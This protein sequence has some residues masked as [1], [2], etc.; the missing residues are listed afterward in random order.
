MNTKWERL[1][2]SFAEDLSLTAAVILKSPKK[3]FSFNGGELFPAASL[4]KLPILW[5]LYRRFQLGESQPDEKAILRQRVKVDGCGILKEL[6]DGLEVTLRDLAT[7]MIVLSDNTAT[8]MLIEKLGMDSINATCEKLGMK[9]TVLSRIMMDYEAAKRGRDNLTT[10]EDMAL[11]FQ[12]LLDGDELGE[13]FRKEMTDILLRQQCN[14]KIPASLPADTPFAHKTGEVP[15]A[16]H[17]C[18][19]LFPQ[20]K[21]AVIIVMT[22]DLKDNAKGIEFHKELGR[23]IADEFYLESKKG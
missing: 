19:I 11:F 14:N 8:N 1:V 13:P 15:G 23:L 9:N 18:G 12:R 17:D 6:H 2:A 22:K 5:E 4:I 16:E 20:D 3:D 21:P 7:L 10:P